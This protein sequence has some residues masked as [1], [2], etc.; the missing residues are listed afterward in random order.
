MHNELS[1]LKKSA[2]ND[3]LI[4]GGASFAASLL[5]NGLVDAFYFL[6]NPFRLGNGLTLFQP[7]DDVQLFTL[8]KSMLFSGGT[9]LLHYNPNQ[10]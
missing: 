10:H 7:N 2:G 9:V 3:I 6:L 4:C 8:I 1:K 5:Q